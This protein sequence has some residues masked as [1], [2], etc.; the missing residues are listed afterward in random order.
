CALDSWLL[1]PG[2]VG[3]LAVLVPPLTL[4]VIIMLV[5]S[6]PLARFVT[7]R[8]TIIILCLGFLLMVGFSLIVQGFGYAV[9]KGYL[10]AA[11]VFSIAIET[12]NQVSRRNIKE[13]EARRPMRERTAEGIL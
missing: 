5:A 10:Y 9:P 2:R 1:S 13:L 7:G 8:P 11:M 4:A 6:E 3:R 12:L